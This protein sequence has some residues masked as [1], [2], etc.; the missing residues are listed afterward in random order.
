MWFKSKLQHPDPAVRQA[1]VEQID[2]DQDVFVTV[3]QDDPHPDVRAAALG[4]IGQLDAL[5]QAATSDDDDRVRKLASGRMQALVAGQVQGSPLDTRMEFLRQTSDSR[6]VRFIARSGV[7]PELRKLAVTR[8]VGSNSDDQVRDLLCEIAVGDTVQEIRES[9]VQP[10]VD[11]QH[12]ER[13]A[14]H[15]RGR[16][17]KIYR[18]VRE[19][20][21]RIEAQ[22]A[23]AQGLQECCDAIEQLSSGEFSEDGKSEQLRL[24]N[25][26]AQWQTHHDVVE[27][28]DSG[29]VARFEEGRS[30]VAQ[31]LAKL[32]ELASQR[33][34]VMTELRAHLDDDVSSPVADLTRRWHD[35]GTATAAQQ[36][37]FDQLVRQVAEHD[38]RR[39]RD[40]SRAVT[41]R[42][43]IEDMRRAAA[44]E[45][46][47]K[48]DLTR[49]EDRWAKS[50]AP[51][52]ATV[53]AELEAEYSALRQSLASRLEKQAAALESDI[54]SVTS[55]LDQYH[56][57][58]EDGKLGEAV[59]L[60]DK[61]VSLMAR[62][63]LPDTQH[64]KLQQRLRDGEPR[65]TELKRWR[66]WGTDRKREE[67]CEKAV[68]LGD[69]DMKIP[70]IARAVREYREQWKALDKSDGPAGK[71]LWHR[72]DSACEKAYEPCQ[73]L[74]NQ[75]KE[76]RAAN[77]EQRVAICEELERLAGE[78]DWEQPA[79]RDIAEKT[80][81][82][83]QRW[84]KAGPVDRRQKNKIQK[85]YDG[86]QAV[87]DEHLG[88]MRK[89][90]IERREK[91]IERVESLAEEPD[92]RNHVQV[93]KQAQRDWK[94]LVQAGRRREQ[95][96]WKRF[97]AACDAVFEK[98]KE[99]FA[100]AD[101]ERA[102]NL[103][104]KKAVLGQVTEMQAE[105]KQVLAG[106]AGTA[107]LAAASRK[108]VK[109]LSAGWRRIGAVPRDKQAIDKEFGKSCSSLLDLCGQLDKHIARQAMEQMRETAQRLDELERQVAAGA[110][111]DAEAVTAV[112]Q[113]ADGF[114]ADF[115]QRARSVAEAAQ[116]DDGAVAK[117]TAGLEDNL[118]KK[119]RLCL[120]MEIAANI[121]SPDEFSEERMQYRVTQLS[122]SL[123]G[124]R[125]TLDPGELEK[126]WYC[127]GAVPA[128]QR[129]ALEQR[130]RRA[131]EALSSH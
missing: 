69:S 118:E 78:T 13:V 46:L 79:W 82:L 5:Q 58:L 55:L 116:G 29:L 36:R 15:A 81:D 103:A 129:E 83:Q 60:H 77:M 122:E 131:L 1:H 73:A 68:A 86:A 14:E 94:P 123:S 61:A 32:H 120:E 111:V 90:E 70:D 47:T 96:L 22:Q 44:G 100:A 109:Q 41:R 26:V 45:L 124:N 24:E 25:L 4:R 39:D 91:L 65:M 87:L 59:P 126:S 67:L 115:R 127:S 37:Q 6:L 57:A 130:F 64:K 125:Q 28:I 53:E 128:D 99:T 71:K 119:R 56:A 63:D 34:A 17:K 43:I 11:Q 113:L 104:E 62:L 108:K 50:K 35:L 9:A 33:D 93:A 76:Q 89:R 101:A 31:R 75:Q 10:I 23:A 72:F 88:T 117:V 12:L 84:H 97:R 106:S 3:L 2:V 110:S 8:L 121:E 16:D 30:A 19:R 107:E 7:E 114:D 102:H 40:Q 18:L 52:D 85:R 112:V 38:S 54:D 48:A 20:L 51:E 80:R 27:D 42:R 92:S 74:F 66:H 98:R 49:L 21:D 95:Q 105:L